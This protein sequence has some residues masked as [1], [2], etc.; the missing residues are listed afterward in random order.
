MI[1]LG[2]KG[3]QVKGK[4]AERKG[5]EKCTDSSQGNR[6]PGSPSHFVQDRASC[7]GSAGNEGIEASSTSLLQKTTY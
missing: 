5:D 6:K 7:R 1:I 2:I 3:R 4:V